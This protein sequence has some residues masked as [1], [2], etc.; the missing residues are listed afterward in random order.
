MPFHSLTN[1]FVKQKKATASPRSLETDLELPK[2]WRVIR[3]EIEPFEGSGVATEEKK[4]EEDEGV[5]LSLSFLPLSPF[6]S[7]SFSGSLVPS[8]LS[9]LSLLVSFPFSLF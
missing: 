8:L 9:F 3:D 1:F 2:R 4:Q 7:L 5:C 6:L